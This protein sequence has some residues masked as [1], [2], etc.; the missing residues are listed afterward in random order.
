M[1]DDPVCTV[2]KNEL[3]EGLIKY[4]QKT[5]LKPKIDLTVK[6]DRVIKNYAAKMLKQL[7]V[8]E[9]GFKL[10]EKEEKKE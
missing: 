4:D 2:K 10:P 3:L 1:R 9:I 8:K 5:K 6:P 7:E